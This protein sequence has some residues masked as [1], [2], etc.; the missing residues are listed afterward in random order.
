METESPRM[1]TF[2]IGCGAIGSGA[3]CL[4]TCTPGTAGALG[5]LA[6]TQLDT[7]PQ[8][9]PELTHVVPAGQAV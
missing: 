4:Q 1:R 7:T 3:P 6:E 9:E 5:S 8:P 2:F